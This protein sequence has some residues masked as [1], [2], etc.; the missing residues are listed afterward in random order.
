MRAILI[1]YSS[2]RSKIFFNFVLLCRGNV[3][4]LCNLCMERS[5][6]LVHKKSRKD[7]EE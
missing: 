4:H 5:K 1:N 2:N 3:I 6:D 7:S